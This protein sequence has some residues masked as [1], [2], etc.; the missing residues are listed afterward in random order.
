MITVVQHL[1]MVMASVMM[2]DRMLTMVCVDLVQIVQIVVHDM[3]MM[4][5]ATMTMRVWDRSAQLWKWT[6]MT[7]SSINPGMLDIGQDGI[8]QDCDGAD[9]PGLCDDTCFDAGDGYCDDGGPNADYQICGFGTDCSDC[10]A[11]VDNDGDGFYDDEGVVPLDSS[12][13]LDCEDQDPTVYPGATE[14]PNDGIDQDC[15]GSDEIVA[16]PFVKIRVPQLMMAYVMMVE[17]MPLM[18]HVLWVQTVRLWRP[19]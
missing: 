15:S 2:V 19:F 17:T 9:Q 16:D 6:V 5:M 18:I 8:D 7:D 14:Q 11:R 3:I 1:G 13:T 12:L 4:V 10:G